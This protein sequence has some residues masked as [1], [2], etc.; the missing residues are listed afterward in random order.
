MVSVRG[1]FV[2]MIVVGGMPVP[3][4]EIVHVIAMGDGLVTAT[5]AV[6]VGVGFRARVRCI[7]APTKRCREID[8]QE[9]A[10]RQQHNLSLI[11]I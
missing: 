7:A 4:V 2:V 10:Q 3:V 8:E 5:G 6:F 1:M 11:H 9:G